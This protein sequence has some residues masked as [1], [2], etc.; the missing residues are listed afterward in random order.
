MRIEGTCMCEDL[1]RSGRGVLEIL[2]DYYC[3]SIT[4]KEEAGMR[5]NYES[6]EL[7]SLVSYIREFALYPKGSGKPLKHIKE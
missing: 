7:Y 6:Y 4:L 3:W 1:E 2:K 5:L